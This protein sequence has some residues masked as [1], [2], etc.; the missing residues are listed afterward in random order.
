MIERDPA[1]ASVAGARRSTTSPTSTLFPEEEAVVAG[2]SRS[3]GA[4]SPPARACAREALAQ[5]GAAPAPILPGR[6]GEPLWPAGVV[7][8]ITHCAGYRAGAVARADELIDDRH[9]RRAPRPLPDG[10]ARRIAL[11]EEIELLA[12]CRSTARGRTGTGCCSAPRSR[13]TRPGSR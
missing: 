6:R 7:G 2:R 4:S 5:L 12:G 8:S 9:R 11:P 1:A 13:S 10:R 3:A